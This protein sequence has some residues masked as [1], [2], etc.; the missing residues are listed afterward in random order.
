MAGRVDE[1]IEEA[2]DEQIDREELLPGE[3]RPIRVPRLLVAASEF[4]W[5]ALIC[6]AFGFVLVYALSRVSFA[7]IPAFIALLLST[8]LIPP[9]RAL[10]RRRVPRALATLLVFLLA[11]GVFAGG[12]AALAPSVAGEFEELPDRLRAGADRLAGIL[13]D[14][15]LNLDEAEVRNEINR[16][17]ERIQENQDAI[18]SGVVSGA[19]IAVTLATQLAVTLVVAFFLVKDGPGLWQWF[20]RL[21]PARRRA[22]ITEM[23]ETSWHALGG[24]V[25]GVAFVALFDSVFIGIALWLIG[26]PLVLPLAVITFFAAFVPLVGAV[27]AGAIAALVALAFNGPVDA[28]LVIGAILLVQQLEG[29]AI[30]PFIVGRSVELHPI[31]ILLS[32]AIGGV[33]AGVV[34]AAI[35]VPIAAVA[36]ATIGVVQRTSTHG[37]VPVG[38]SASAASAADTAF[39]DANG[40]R[41]FVRGFPVRGRRRGGGAQSDT[42]PD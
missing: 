32:V 15:P 33:L 1:E 37:E 5:R 23:G 34:G 36:S 7:V 39:I 24:Y 41:D 8:L 28:L 22:A 4:S 21:F 17:D 18:T 2:V 38:P 14:S 31:V 29:N 12:V 26:V 20:L 42:R 16:V 13:A 11:F 35:A 3:V 40:L 25:K 6:L 9:V 27:V 10:Q 19:Q 30:Y